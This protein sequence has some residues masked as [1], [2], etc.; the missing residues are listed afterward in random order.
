M[1]SYAGDMP[2]TMSAAKAL[3]QSNKK[4]QH[5]LFWKKRISDVRKQI[6]RLLQ[7]KNLNADI[8]NKEL[9]LLAKALDKAAKEKVIHK[10][11]ANRLKSRYARKITVQLKKSSGAAANE[12]SSSATTAAAGRKKPARSKS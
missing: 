8:L 4:R 1:L 2:N 12:V 10:N 5:N 9:S 6:S 3:R 11:K 7:T